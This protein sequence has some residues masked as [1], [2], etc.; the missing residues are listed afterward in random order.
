MKSRIVGVL[1]TAAFC[2]AGAAQA[3]EIEARIQ[4]GSLS[5]TGGHTYTNAKLQIIGPQGFEKEEEALRGM[6]T[7]RVQGA[8]RMVDGLYQYSLVAASDEK[9]PLE[10]NL[11]NGRGA[12]AQNFAYKPFSMYGTF[13]VEKGVILPPE[14]GAGG[15]DTDSE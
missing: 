8:G 9:V 5:F 6:P 4:S 14:K 3:A 13:R 2:L 10:N 12:N 11:D 1:C 15:A 7:F